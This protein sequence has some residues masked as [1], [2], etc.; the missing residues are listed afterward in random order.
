[1]SLSF[2][3]SFSVSKIMYLVCVKLLLFFFNQIL[4]F[5]KSWCMLSSVWEIC[6][7]FFFLR[8]IKSLLI[9]WRYNFF[10]LK[11]EKYNGYV[12]CILCNIYI[13]TLLDVTFVFS[14]SRQAS[15]PLIKLT[16]WGSSTRFYPEKWHFIQV[17]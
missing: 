8:C 6:I 15:N 5:Q 7:D 10:N 4:L 17:H 1:M 3:R 16:F 13:F 14:V 2:H 12:D 9:V 11:R